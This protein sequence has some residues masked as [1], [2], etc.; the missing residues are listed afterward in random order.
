M[1]HTVKG[2]ILEMQL[3]AKSKGG[4][5][6][7]KTYI[8]SKTNLWWEC[9]QGH[10]WLS[11]PL[12]VKNRKSWC[13]ICANNVPIGLEVMK[14]L[15]IEHGGKCLSERYLNVKTKLHWQCSKGHRFYASGVSIRKGAWCL[16]CKQKGN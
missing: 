5:C 8:N 1:G 10:R 13:P 16:K 9:K 2:T 4:I 7:S 3:L 6:W 11:T 12:S 15:A 14:K